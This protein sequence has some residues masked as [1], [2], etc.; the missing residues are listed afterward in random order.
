MNSYNETTTGWVSNRPPPATF[1]GTA[2]R[3]TPQ[4]PL[5]AVAAMLAMTLALGLLSGIVALLAVW[6]ISRDGG[7]GVRMGAAI[8]LGVTMLATGFWLSGQRRA[9][10]D[11]DGNIVTQN[12]RV[13]YEHEEPR[14]M[15][16]MFTVETIESG[17]PAVPMLPAPRIVRP[18]EWSVKTPNGKYV[19]GDFDLSPQLIAEWCQAA[20]EGRSLAINNWK[21]KFALPDGSGGQL[22]YEQFLDQLVHRGAL[23]K[24][25]GSVGYRPTALGW[26]V[27]VGTLNG[28]A[29]PTLPAPEDEDDVA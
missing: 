4:H 19:L 25:G 27:V 10:R 9:V 8:W 15:A 13:C 22:R 1:T 24:V 17:A 11:R 12:G 20:A 29:P 6:V 5:A 21:E 2:R 23:K 26:N 7:T 28:G 3:S 14:L 16:I 18:V